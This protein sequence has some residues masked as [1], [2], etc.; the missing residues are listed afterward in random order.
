MS[1]TDRELFG[2]TVGFERPTLPRNVLLITLTLIAAVVVSSFFGRYAI[3]VA[4]FRLRPEQVAP[5]VLAAWMLVV[6]ELRRALMRTA[7]HPVVVVF[8]A[9][10]AWNVGST[11]LF[12]PS[13]GWS[14]S[15]LMWL[16]IDLLLLSSLMALDSGAAFAGRLGRTS[17]VPWA[18]LGF[19]AF[20]V[21][22]LTHGAFALGTD[23]DWLYEI[24]VARVT[25][26]EANIYASILIFWAIVAIAQKRLSWIWVGLLAISVP[27]GL[28]A[29]QTRTSV[30]SLLAGLVVFV[31]YTLVRRDTAWGARLARALP[32]GILIAT[33]LV[34]YVATSFV[35]PPDGPP[36][37]Q[38]SSSAAEEYV[39]DPSNPETT[40][41][42]SDIDVEGGT[43]GFRVT[44]AKLAAEDMHGVN[45]WFGNGTNT[46]GLRHDQPGTPG[47]SG[48]I[49]MLPV[50]VLYDAGIVGLALLT[51][52]FALVF[53]YTPRE[54]K[55][56]AAGLLA[57]YIISATLTSMFW[58][59]ITWILIAVLLRPLDNERETSV[60]R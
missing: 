39:P 58:F 41:K 19:G 27:L 22:N 1:R 42:I 15:I 31:V 49:I 18:L 7:R 5:V 51:T 11:L 24:Y 21:A 44:V 36:R 43:I 16:V 35:A 25:A 6:P 53:V 17:V 4:G 59:A 13:L 28:I 55:P 3:P 50:Q 29:S 32:A 33:V 10:I 9:F 14:I 12:S 37:P 56:L 30:F 26:I 20:V 38:P 23:F 45:L 40:N 54:K 46:F 47:T 34:S 2:S 48:H 52:L 57:S 60:V 8:A